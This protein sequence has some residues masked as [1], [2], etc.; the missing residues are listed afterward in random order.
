MTWKRGARVTLTQGPRTFRWVVKAPQNSDKQMTGNAR[1]YH[2]SHQLTAQALTT[3]SPPHSWSWGSLRSVVA[4]LD[5]AI[6]VIFLLLFFVDIKFSRCACISGFLAQTGGQWLSASRCVLT[7][8][9]L[10]AAASPYGPL[11]MVQCL[12][13]CGLCASH[14]SI[15]CLLF[16]VPGCLRRYARCMVPSSPFHGRRSL[17][18]VLSGDGDGAYET[19]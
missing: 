5:L 6:S 1:E 17:S 9:R 12:G 16:A 3:W 2:N 10:D 7:A 15:C 14:E 13:T 18:Q 19:S 11:Q 4:Q 8:W